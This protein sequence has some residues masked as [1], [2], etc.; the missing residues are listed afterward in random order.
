MKN[1]KKILVLITASMLGL[2]LSGCGRDNYNGNYTGSETKIPQ[3]GQAG[4]MGFPQ[5]GMG[6]QSFRGVTAALSHNGE[7]VTGTYTISQGVQQQNQFPGSTPV[8]VTPETYRFEANARGSN[9]LTAVRLIP[10]TT[11]G[12]NTG[13]GAGCALEGTLTAVEN[14]RRITGTLNPTAMNMNM[15]SNLCFP[16]Q[17]T[18]DRAN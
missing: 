16:T 8:A 3:A 11:G 4:Q 7:I 17:I 5:M 12:F 14:G 6:Q 1:N 10:M 15:M 13:F 18:L 9:E 2:A